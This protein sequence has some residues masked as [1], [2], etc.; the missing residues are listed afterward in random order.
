MNELSCDRK[1]ALPPSDSSKYAC[2]VVDVTWSVLFDF[3]FFT[4][5]YRV[6][7]NKFKNE[8]I[9]KKCESDF[10]YDPFSKACRAIL[11]GKT[12]DFIDV[13]NC[14]S[15]KVYQANEFTFLN[16]TIF[17]LYENV[18]LNTSYY[19]YFP[20]NNT[21]IT[22]V[23]SNSS[24]AES[25]LLLSAVQINENEKFS[26]I[27]EIL[28]KVGITLSLIGLGLLLFIY[29]LF[30]KLR[31][32][33]GLNLICLCVSYITV[34]LIIISTMI[35]MKYTEGKVRETS[36]LETIYDWLFYLLAVLLNYACLSTYSWMR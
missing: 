22:C 6:G 21:L 23:L 35:L 15:S 7:F 30:S 29:L 8:I 25:D 24:L 26:Y 1:K 11:F 17:L 10:F 36:K 19:Q 14:E 18:L 12:R 31:N 3:N 32:L 4:G 5:E 9:T 28:T 33:P 13:A 27:H 34:Y 16:E 20:H 2:N